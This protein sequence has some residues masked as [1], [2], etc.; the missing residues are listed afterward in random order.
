MQGMTGIYLDK[1]TY[2]K[3]FYSVIFRPSCVK[4]AVMNTKNKRLHHRVLWN[5]AVPKILPEEC[6]K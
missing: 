6:K 1:G 2:V 4:V 3:S 5:N